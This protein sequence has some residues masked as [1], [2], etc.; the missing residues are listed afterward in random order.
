LVERKNIE[1]GIDAAS[2]Q[3]EGMDAA[4]DYSCSVGERMN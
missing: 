2:A 4:V 3:V 1:N